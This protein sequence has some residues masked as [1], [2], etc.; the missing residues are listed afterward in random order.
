MTERV[1][2]LPISSETARLL[3]E[4]LDNGPYATEAEVIA[5]ALE[6]WRAARDTA[7]Q[8]L[9]GLWA[10]G[11]ASGPGRFASIEDIKDEARRRAAPP[12][13]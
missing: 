5:E 12:S 2:E 10:D 13:E 3:R 4:A 6:Q 9:R 1:L 8:Q 7:G 11:L